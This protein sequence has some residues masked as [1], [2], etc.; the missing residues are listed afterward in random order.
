MD[1]KIVKV[2]LQ[3]NFAITTILKQYF[4]YI[5]LIYGNF[6]F[7][8]F[9]KIKICW[10]DIF[11]FEF[12]EIDNSTNSKSLKKYLLFHTHQKGGNNI[13]PYLSNKTS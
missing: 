7:G 1:I 13:I 2:L 11:F 3:Q 10:K 5:F 4:S 9:C 12:F 8:A 6:Y